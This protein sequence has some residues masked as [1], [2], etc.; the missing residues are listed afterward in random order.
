[1]KRA[2]KRIIG[3]IVFWAIVLSLIII[4]GPFFRPWDSENDSWHY[5]YAEEKDSV[6]V[7]VIGSSAIY[8]YWIPPQAYE[9]QGFTSFM[10]AQGSQP[11]E[12]VPYI[13]EEAVKTQ[14][15]DV[16]VVETR[17]A[18]A[19]RAKMN[20]GT[21]NQ[22]KVTYAFSRVASGMR[23]SLVRAQ[24]IDDVL[25]E[26]DGNK[27]LEWIFPL[28]KYHDNVLKFSP[29]Q[30]KERLTLGKQPLKGADQI[31]QV[32]PYTQPTGFDDKAY[33]L[34]EQDKKNID[35]IAE[36]AKELNKELVFV[37]T[38][39]VTTSYRYSLQLDMDAY[40]EEKGYTYVDLQERYEE[41]GLNFETDFYNTNHVNIAGAKKVTSYLAEFLSDHYELRKAL[42]E[43]RKRE[44]DQVLAEW[45]EEEKALLTE[46]EENCKI[47]EEEAMSS[48]K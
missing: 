10:I 39:Y 7:L 31:A 20:R 42:P 29:S 48:V 37:A 17:Q 33:A 22:E 30:V 38:P 19:D 21:Y 25:V 45:K 4:I 27:K 5:Y 44:W 9:E 3:A 6:S 18:I 36:K 1:M 2:G 15:P 26:D 13:M 11:I 23:P 16:I 47:V 8:R 46:W 32:V 14:D 34:D 24:M 40:M 35:L 28:L 41:L 12:A 43:D